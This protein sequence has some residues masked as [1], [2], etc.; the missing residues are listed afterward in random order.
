MAYRSGPLATGTVRSQPNPGPGL[1][2]SPCTIFT[3]THYRSTWDVLYLIGE[4]DG[5]VHDAGAVGADRVGDVPDADRVEVL[6]VALRLHEDLREVRIEKLEMQLHIS[7][8]F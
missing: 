4:V 6:V 5:G 1:A 2:R 7:Q 3:N 8:P